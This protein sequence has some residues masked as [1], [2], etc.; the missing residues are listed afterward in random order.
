MGSKIKM[1]LAGA[2]IG[3]MQVGDDNVQQN[4][5]I[6]GA[7]GAEDREN[8]RLVAAALGDVGGTGELARE[9]LCLADVE[10][11]RA[12]DVEE[13]RLLPRLAERAKSAFRATERGLAIYDTLPEPLKQWIN[14]TAGIAGMSGL[15]G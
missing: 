14:R 9:L 2:R 11:E 6:E 13:R 12:L 5:L 1:N 10:P 8:L 3:A 15:G 7:L 4:V